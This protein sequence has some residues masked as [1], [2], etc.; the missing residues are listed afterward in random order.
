MQPAPL[1]W[2]SGR[3]CLRL[4]LRGVTVP[5]AGRAAL[6]VGTVVSALSQGATIVD[7]T[8]T[9]LT[10]LLVGVNYSV[11]FVVASI[12]FLSARRGPAGPKGS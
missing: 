12:G 8:A 2:S 3:E 10:W 7:G 11:P 5:T 6:V 1:T 4:F 9:W